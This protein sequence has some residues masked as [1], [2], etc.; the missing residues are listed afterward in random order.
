M[1]HPSKSRF[2]TALLPALAVAA[3]LPVEVSAQAGNCNASLEAE[4]DATAVPKSDAD[5]AVSAPE[6]GGADGS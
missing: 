4:V 2:I 1:K 5:F 6:T 3:F